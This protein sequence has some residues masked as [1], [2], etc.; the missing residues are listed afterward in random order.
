MPDNKIP[1]YLE[2]ERVKMFL[3]W[4]QFEDKWERLFS[5][6]FVGSLSVHRAKFNPNIKFEWRTVEEEIF[7][8]K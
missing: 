5:D 1:I 7:E 6:E 8:K 2:P 4:C 3:K